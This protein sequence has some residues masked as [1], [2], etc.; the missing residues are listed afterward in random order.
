[1]GLAHGQERMLALIG[2]LVGSNTLQAISGQFLL[3]CD[4]LHNSLLTSE[5]V[6]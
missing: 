2:D 1:V 3:I 5:G 6:N 4:L